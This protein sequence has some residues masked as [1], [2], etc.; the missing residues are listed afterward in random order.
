MKEKIV[1]NHFVWAVE[2]I[3]GKTWKFTSPGRKGVADRIACL[4]DGSTW[5]VE[6]KTKG[7]RLSA[8]QKMFMSDMTLLNQNYMCLW[9]TEQIDEFVKTLPRR[10]R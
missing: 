10:S 2:R 4:P 9:T 6:L 3:G 8:L 1:E 5:F 7:G